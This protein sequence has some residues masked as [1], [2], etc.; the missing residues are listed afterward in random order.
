MDKQDGLEMT[1]V[2]FLLM[3]PSQ[4]VYGIKQDRV[5]LKLMCMIAM[6]RLHRNKHTEGFVIKQASHML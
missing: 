3:R 1:L 6:P 4:S 5:G 2:A